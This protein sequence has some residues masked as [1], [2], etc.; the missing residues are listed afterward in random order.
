LPIFVIFV[1]A[2]IVLGA[3]AM[4][5]PALPT[6]GPRIGLAATLTLA[7]VVT[8][9]LFWAA[10]F[11]WDTLNI[12]YLWFAMLVVIFLAGTMSAGMFRAEAKG[13][14]EE[15][16]GWPGPRELAFFTMVGI[17][18]AAP[19]LTLPV[20]MDTDAQGF[21]Y[22][23]LTLR[24]GGSLTTLAPYHP[25]ITYLYSPGF[26]AL[27]AYLGRQLNAGL[28]NIQLGIGAV[29]CV[30]FVWL[31]YDF[32]NELDRDKVRRTGLVMAFCALIGTGLLTADLDSHYTTLLGLVFALAFLTFAVR[33]HR[34][35]RRG[36]FLG[37]AVTLAAVPLSQPDM[38][39]I[40][41]LGYVPWL[42]TMWLAAPRPTFR[43]W[44]GLA[45]GIPLL[46]LIGIV[47]W[48]AKIAP[49]LG[50]D[51]H[52]PFEISTRHLLV[53]VVY[54]GGVIVLLSLVGIV[55]AVRRRN[56]VDL[57]M[58]VWLALIVDFS[59]LGILQLIAPG[60]LAPIT[61]YDYPFSLAW[62]GPIIPYIYFGATALLWLM[63]RLGRDRVENWIKLASLPVINVVALAVVLLMLYAE[64]LA[65]ATKN[66]PLQIYGAFASKAD[67]QAMQWLQQNSP[68]DALVLNHPGPQEGDWAPII[69]Q[70]NSVYFRDQPFFRNTEQV[71]AQQQALR[72]FWQNPG[73]PAN[74]AL[75]ARYSVS[76]VIVPQV[77]NRPDALKTMF[78][79]RAPIP[80]AARYKPVG[81]VPYLKLVYDADGAQVYQV[82]SSVAAR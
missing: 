19:A 23:A 27:V 79:W 41:V 7:L 29:L 45:A 58:L 74:A 67:V 26:P 31:A 51:I 48:L 54:H 24:N 59:S 9:A 71:K 46:A 73:D 63:E 2:S 43:R 25:E 5:A 20:P 3:G 18:F 15:Y 53:M 40:L 52:S 12:D 80:E 34:E 69:A 56:A 32:G 75:L 28:Q 81:D 76:Y 62:H 47:P 82:L 70:R 66:S 8:G 65:A 16:G 60:L 22:L 61:K 72:A 35:G 37:A 49:L 42:A 57:L 10:L 11:K 33:F 77:V 55:L 13:K 38:T 21:G 68:T 17:L 4:L 36:D 44:L 6:H 50:S 64:P 78:R 39:I 30:L 14:D 1:F